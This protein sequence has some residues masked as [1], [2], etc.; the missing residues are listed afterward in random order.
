MFHCFSATAVLFRFIALYRKSVATASITMMPWHRPRHRT[1][2][3]CFC[4]PDNVLRYFG[5]SLV[6]AAA[7]DRSADVFESCCRL[8]VSIHACRQ[9][10][11][12]ASANPCRFE[13]RLL[14]VIQGAEGSV[15]PAATAPLFPRYNQTAL[16]GLWA[17]RRG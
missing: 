8:P 14:C 12:R 2:K 5:W 3:F 11:A 17:V 7:I 9:L 10:P 6:R 15:D 4:L 13:L 16:P 1:R